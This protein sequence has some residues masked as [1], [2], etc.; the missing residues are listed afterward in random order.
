M[1]GFPTCQF[2]GEPVLVTA[3]SGWVRGVT[4]WETPRRQGGANAIL[5]RKL[6]GDFAHER[7]V[8]DRTTIEAQGSLL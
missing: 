4:G 6:T 8:K 1:S 7:C 5:N 2:C 3:R